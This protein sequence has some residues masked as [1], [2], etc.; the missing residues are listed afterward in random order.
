[1]SFTRG[2]FTAIGPKAEYAVS[3]ENIEV[4]PVGTEDA[5]KWR[6][7]QSFSHSINA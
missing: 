1:M 4:A 3:V 6:I 5:T 2:A 7:I